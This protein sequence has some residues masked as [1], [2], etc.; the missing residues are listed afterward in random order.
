[1]DYKKAVKKI[2]KTHKKIILSVYRRSP[3]PPGT[4]GRRRYEKINQLVSD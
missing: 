2:I 3:P 1:M 4:G